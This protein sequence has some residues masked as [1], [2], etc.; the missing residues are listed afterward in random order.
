MTDEIVIVNNGD[1]EKKEDSAFDQLAARLGGSMEDIYE[2]MTW[3]EFLL[4]ASGSMSMPI[5]LYDEK[6]QYEWDEKTLQDAKEKLIQAINQEIEDGE[7]D[8]EDSLSKNY[9]STDIE[10]VKQAC[11]DQV[12]TVTLPPLKKDAHK[13]SDL[14]KLEIVR[15]CAKMFLEK[16]FSKYPDAKVGA[17]R[18]ES[19][20][21][22]FVAGQDKETTI[23]AVE[24]NLLGT[25]GGTSMLQ[26]L[27]STMNKLRKSRGAAHHFVLVTDGQP[28]DTYG[29]G[30]FDH[31]I[32]PFQ[33]RKIVLDV[34]FIL[35]RNYR[36]VS[37][38]NKT[39]E[40]NSLEKLANATGGTIE[41]VDSEQG[42]E[43]KFLAVAERKLL[44]TGGA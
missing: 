41:Y 20:V 30:C 21:Y 32:E 11:V 38:E 4:D 24:D 9:D 18:F 6:N 39:P 29:E 26:A 27:T 40:I 1:N 5:A 15:R 10:D 43:Q 2:K 33:G 14:S 19:T 17:V 12:V 3:V 28:T 42:F 23:K 36:N 25:G 31:L 7:D 16:R 22:E 44:G 35:D 37:K 8:Y 13:L 34:I